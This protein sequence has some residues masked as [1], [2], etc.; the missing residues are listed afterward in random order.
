METVRETIANGKHIWCIKTN[1]LDVTNAFHSSLVEPLMS[2]LRKAGEDLIW[3]EPT[4]PLERATKG[5]SAVIPT[6]SFV[7][8][9]MRDPVYF[10][11]A[12]QRLSKRFPSGIWREAG[13]NST[14]TNAASRALSSPK[15]SYFQPINGA[16]QFLTDATTSLWKEGLNMTF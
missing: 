6:P 9:H 15:S 10:N 11:H 5:E 8:N 3:R 7:A 4:I 13:S 12:V 1:K 14:I 2:D 16:S